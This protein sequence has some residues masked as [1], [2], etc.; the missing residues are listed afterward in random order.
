MNNFYFFSF[1]E[2]C[3]NFFKFLQILPNRLGFY[4][5]EINLFLQKMGMEKEKEKQLI[6]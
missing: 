4:F 5:G 3:D 2:F 1:G 6:H